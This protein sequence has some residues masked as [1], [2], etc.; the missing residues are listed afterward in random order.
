MQ[1]ITTLQSEIRV[2]SWRKYKRVA[3]PE[4]SIE[5]TRSANPSLVVASTIAVFTPT[6]VAIFGVKDARTELLCKMP[7][8]GYFEVLFVF[9]LLISFPEDDEIRLILQVRRPR[10]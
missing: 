7:L 10:Q 9:D 6:V 2:L 4:K 8:N 3:S 1:S 5:P